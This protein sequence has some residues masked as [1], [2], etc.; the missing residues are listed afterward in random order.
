MPPISV[1]LDA[2]DFDV[3]SNDGILAN[4]DRRIWAVCNIASAMDEHRRRDVDLD[5]VVDG[6]GALDVWRAR[7]YSVRLFWIDKTAIDVTGKR[8]TQCPTNL[9][10]P[11]L[12]PLLHRGRQSLVVVDRAQHLTTFAEV[13]VLVVVGEKVI[14]FK[15]HDV[16]AL[17]RALRALRDCGR[18]CELKVVI[19]VI[20]HIAALPI[21]ICL[22]GVRFQAMM[23]LDVGVC[24][25]IDRQREHGGVGQ[26]AVLILQS[27]S[28]TVLLIVRA[29]ARFTG[30]LQRL[31]KLQN[32][33]PY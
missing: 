14:E 15:L 9:L 25:S 21:L 7:F 12:C 2:K 19:V 10:V 17:L 23:I 1:M 31:E 13:A 6:D 11:R 26:A 27:L 33:W 18:V 28:N 4:A 16:F 30:A 8:I 22:F 5:P 20:F 29:L 24:S 32:D 3:G